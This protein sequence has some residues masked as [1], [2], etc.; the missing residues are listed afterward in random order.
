MPRTGEQGLGPP[1]AEPITG[2]GGQERGRLTSG[3][4]GTGAG[5][6]GRAQ[7]GGDVAG[8]QPVIDGIGQGRPQDP[9][10]LCAVTSDTEAVAS[11]CM[12]RTSPAVRSGSRIGPR[13][14]IRCRRTTV[15]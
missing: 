8:D 9:V 7:S 3:Q 1:G 15:S 6:A 12:R 13:A 4:R 5:R 2:R 10:G 14:G 11:R